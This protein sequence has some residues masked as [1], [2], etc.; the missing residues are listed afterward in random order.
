MLKKTEVKI[1]TII[2][3]ECVLEGDF[4]AGGSVRLDGTVEGN[5]K[6][7]GHLLVGATGKI[8]GNI[9]ALSAV[10][11]GEVTGN[12]TA[13]EKVE[14]TSTARVIGDLRTNAIVIDE[15]AIFQGKC[16]MN[17]EEAKPK[18]RPAKEKK[19]GKK[20]AKDAL[21]EALKEAEAEAQSAAVTEEVVEVR[22]A[23]VEAA[24]AVAADNV[25]GEKAEA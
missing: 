3:K 25:A 14:L 17:Q 1:T 8:H 18:K 12:V 24:E 15:K 9:E 2:G 19:A 5:V 22:T 21:R 20:S 23:A 7:E 6:V 11:G 16:D 4:Q 13:P 10:I